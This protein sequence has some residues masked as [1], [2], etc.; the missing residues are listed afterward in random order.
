MFEEGSDELAEVVV[1]PPGV[2]HSHALSEFGEPDR[3]ERIVGLPRG[4]HHRLEDRDARLVTDE[5]ERLVG[6]ERF[7]RGVGHGAHE[8]TDGKE[9]RVG[10]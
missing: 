4:V 6:R 10:R 1:E 3:G 2:T 9:V 8:G 7:R 5:R